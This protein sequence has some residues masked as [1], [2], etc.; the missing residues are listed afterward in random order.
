MAWELYA[1]DTCYII[2]VEFFWTSYI[3]LQGN[4]IANI[5]DK[6][7][8]LTIVDDRDLNIN[9]QRRVAD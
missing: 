3:E 4:S 8:L 5:L 2:D 7:R 1:Y 9:I 6:I